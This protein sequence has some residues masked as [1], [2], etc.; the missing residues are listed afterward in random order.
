LNSTH[1]LLYLPRLGRLGQFLKARLN[2]PE[3]DMETSA[4]I[5][6]LYG[7]E[8]SRP[9][10]NLPFGWRNRNVVVYT[11]A[12]KKVLKTFRARWPLTTIIY[13]HSI[14]K[15]LEMRN[16]AAP[17]LVSTSSGETWVKRN[18]RYFAL[19]N[20]INGTNLAASVMLRSQ[21]QMLIARAGETL[22]QFHKLLTDFVP[23][24]RHHLGYPSY[25]GDRHRDLAWHLNKLEELCEKSQRLTDLEGKK[26]A[27]WLIEKSDDLG[28]KL[29]R[30]D[31]TLNRAQ[32]PRVVIHGD[33]GIHNLLF[34]HEGRVTMHDFELARIEWRLID[35]V[36]VLSRHDFVEGRIFMEAYRSEYDLNPDE[37]R[38]L[39]QVWQYYRLQGA[40]QYWHNYFEMGG[41]HRLAA[42]RDRIK[43]AD[44]ALDHRSQLWQL[45]T[46][47]EG[48]APAKPL[49]IMM[50]VRL[51][52]PWIGGTERQAYK[53]SQKLVD[54]GVDV[55]LVTGWWFR[56]TTQREIIGT[57]PIY[58]NFT[59]WEFFGIKGLR[60][61]GG[62]LYIISLLWYLWRRRDDYDLIHVHG[63][64]YHTFAAVLAG[65]WFKRK[66][67]T[68]L[69]NSGFASD[70][71]K[72]RNSKQLALAKYMLSTALK[73]N[74]FVA[75][76]KKIVQELTTAG[77]QRQNVIELPNGVETDAVAAKSDYTLHNPARIVFIGRLHHQKGLDILL[78]A[79]QQVYLNYPDRDLRLEL[80]GDGPLKE[81]LLDLA[82]RL[83]IDS[84]VTFHGK[85]D[86]VDEHLQDADVFVL[87]SRAE[88]LSNALLEAMAYGLPVL[89]SD[90]PG[91][92]DVI[93]H[94][95]NGLLFAV[96][97][98]SALTKYL[99][100]L[101]DK[102]DL[103][104]RLGRQ[105][106][107]TVEN[108]YSLNTVAGRYIA[109]YQDLLA[110]NKVFASQVAR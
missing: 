18:G 43:Q 87:P 32:L 14:L 22:A 15:Q 3:I 80:L 29:S 60:K 56:D 47:P 4:Q 98:P 48:E 1:R 78:K 25:M 97:D 9:P 91:N 53:L 74:R 37:W 107:Q 90:I 5:L 28:E 7:L 49:R 24:G 39:P 76:N 109:L 38:Y 104:E 12:G 41:I 66:I 10:E 75:L 65:D 17:R 16:F 27:D 77:V 83:G 108:H 46:S 6:S 13:E 89:V 55:E 82:G 8:L 71:D 68:K 40:V 100:S 81:H 106:R 23:E 26:Q 44:W 21:R 85:T 52:Y 110:G 93:E 94:G 96:D 50:V 102:P 67:V 95:K 69:A 54:K 57:V 79:F 70:I 42:A 64:N 45:R 62:Y 20:F 73:C 101:L 84:Q 105:A 31:E 51:F 88:G 19:L 61:F 103:R 86:H 63:L 34:Q 58:R 11:S 35:L 2:A 59:L 36:G 33:Y 72:M 92:L 99:V 30:L